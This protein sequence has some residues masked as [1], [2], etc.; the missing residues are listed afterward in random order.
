MKL[1]DRARRG[2]RLVGDGSGVGGVPNV[3][4]T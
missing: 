3:E 2:V 1:F 4:R